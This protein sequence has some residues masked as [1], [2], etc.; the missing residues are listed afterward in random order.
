MPY[1]GFFLVYLEGHT[2][3]A[4]NQIYLCLNFILFSNFC[5]PFRMH[6]SSSSFISIYKSFHILKVFRSWILWILEGLGIKKVMEKDEIF[7]QTS[8]VELKIRLKW[9]WR[10]LDSILFNLI[11]C[12]RFY[13]SLD[14]WLMWTWLQLLR[15]LFT[16]FF[17]IC[18]QGTFFQIKI[19]LKKPR[20]N[21]QMGLY[22]LQQIPHDNTQLLKI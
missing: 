10:S 18:T 14:L 7:F 17:C 15:R 1:F 13:I 5:D 2:P 12:V 19:K 6:Y 16:F 4:H 20:A 3:R 11:M 22:A 8:F 9:K 21:P